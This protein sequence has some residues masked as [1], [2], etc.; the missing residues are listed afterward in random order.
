MGSKTSK[1]TV[2]KEDSDSNK[3]KT[4][5]SLPSNSNELMIDERPKKEVTSLPK[6]IHVASLSNPSSSSSTKN[7]LTVVWLDTEINN[8]PE[9]TDTQTKLKNLI[10]Y[11]RIF[12]DIDACTQY[13]EQ[14]GY[15]NTSNLMNEE[16]LLMIISSTLA[17]TIIPQFHDLPQIKYFYIY[18]TSKINAKTS[19]E[20]LKKYPKIK[21]VY[22]TSRSLLAQIAQD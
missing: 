4:L 22:S 16:K 12:D 18:G 6:L 2:E 7:N 3:N 14:T 20:M 5:S 8:Q 1:Y 11:I 15:M 10:C 9:H 19:Q 21:G 13:I 17:F